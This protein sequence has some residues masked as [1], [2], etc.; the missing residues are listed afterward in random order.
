[1]PSSREA[2]RKEA[3]LDPLRGRATLRDVAK[4]AG[5]TPMTVSNVVNGRAGQVGAEV[6]AR[7]RAACERLDYRPHANARRLRTNRRQA[8]GVVIVDPSPFYV[9]DPL[10]A[11]MLAGLTARLGKHGYSTVLHGVSPDELDAAPLLRQIESDGICLMLSGS[12]SKRRAALD[13]VRALGQPLLLLQ[14]ELPADLAD[15]ASIIQDDAGGAAA[16]ATHLLDGGIASAVMLVPG[17]DWPAM[18]R[19]EAGIRAVFE[20]APRPPRFDVVRCGDEG[21]DST[22]AALAAHLDRHGVPDAV[23]GGNDQMAIAGMKLL[24]A[25]GLD[26]PGDVLVTGF[27]GLD[28]WRYATPELTT[29]FSPAYA[30]GET[31]GEA[32]LNRLSFGAF[33]FRSRV[34]PVRL[35]PHGS[36]LPLPNSAPAGQAG[37]SPVDR[38]SAT[39]SQGES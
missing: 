31:A 19:R 10:T 12:A 3:A 33:P 17:Q 7:V 27:N 16:V 2:V 18:E 25:R 39:S 15:A 4:L 8:V 22:A 26:V 20:A 23:I 21:F 34:L 1:M 6:A 37:G 11:A 38:P 36:S 5:T 30:I 28:F 29:V 13:R 14:E 24:Q 32:M 35:A 9:S